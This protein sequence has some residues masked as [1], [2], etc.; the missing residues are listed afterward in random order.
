MKKLPRYLILTL[1]AMTLAVAGCSSKGKTKPEDAVGGPGSGLTTGGEGAAGGGEGMGK[2][3]GQ[4][5]VG[6]IPGERVVYFDYDKSDV[7]A[8]AR[9]VLEAHAAYLQSHPV[10]IRLEGHADERGSREYNLALGERRAESV[11]RALVIMG[12]TESLMNTLS[13]GEEH[14]LDPGHNETPS[15]TCQFHRIYAL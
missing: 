5:G 9:A 15:L 4:G 11:K 7:R 13:Y 6:A 1:L 12:V 8:D 14:P 3:A 10:S 2:D